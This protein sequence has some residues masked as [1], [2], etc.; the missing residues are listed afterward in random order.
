MRC[1][2]CIF[3]ILAACYCV[4]GQSASVRSSLLYDAT[5]NPGAEIALSN[6][7]T[8]DI[9][10]DYNPWQYADNKKLKRRMGNRNHAIGCGIRRFATIN[11]EYLF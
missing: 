2:F 7:W 3:F 5:I 9:S 8:L 6:K 10:G 1:I 11:Y 4:K